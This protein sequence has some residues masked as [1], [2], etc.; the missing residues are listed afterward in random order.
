MLTSTGHLPTA[1]QMANR[2]Q[3]PALS[4]TIS[5]MLTK[6]LNIG[7]SGR[8]GTCKGQEEACQLCL[9]GPSQARG[10]SW[11]QRD[12]TPPQPREHLGTATLG[13][14]PWR[15]ASQG[16]G[17]SWTATVQKQALADPAMAQNL[18]GV[19]RDADAELLGAALTLKFN[20]ALLCGCLQT[21]MV[22]MSRAMR[23]STRATIQPTLAS[24]SAVTLRVRTTQMTVISVA[25][26]EGAIRGLHRMWPPW[27]T[28]PH[29]QLG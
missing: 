12:P 13:T 19:R 5:R 3:V 9:K 29:Q 26:R 28:K 27:D 22:G 14:A 20:R 6:M 23:S 15:A 16:P 17:L 24:F 4:C 2:T 7:R 18:L 1:I 25:A 11:P 21:M 10:C 8:K